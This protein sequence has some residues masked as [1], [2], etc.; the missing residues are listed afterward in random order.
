MKTRI[1]TFVPQSR[2]H[3]HCKGVSGIDQPDSDKVMGTIRFLYS[4]K[5]L[6]DS[7]SWLERQAVILKV[8]GHEKPTGSENHDRRRRLHNQYGHL[9][10]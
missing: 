10:P 6:L 4:N 1:P 9:V 2:G 8:E 5:E 3:I 7:L